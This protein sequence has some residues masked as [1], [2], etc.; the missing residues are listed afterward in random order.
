MII[1]EARNIIGLPLRGI[2]VLEGGY[3]ISIKS[4]ITN[5]NTYKG[6]HNLIIININA[7]I[8]IRNI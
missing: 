8:I 1:E 5:N 7:G 3:Y 2:I 4:N 6:G